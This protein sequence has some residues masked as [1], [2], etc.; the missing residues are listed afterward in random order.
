[1][2]F[3]DDEFS[4]S[5][6]TIAKPATVKAIGEPKKQTG[7]AIEVYCLILF[8]QCSSN[9]SDSSAVLCFKLKFEL[10]N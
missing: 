5:A 9:E 10:F 1:M 8:Y 3:I 7:A 6:A 4:L 2:D